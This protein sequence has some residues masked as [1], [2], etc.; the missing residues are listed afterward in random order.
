V[1]FLIL[2]ISG[3]LMLAMICGV[4][5]GWALRHISASTKDEQMQRTL[6]DARARVPQF[7][8]LIRSRDVQINHLKEELKD[9]DVRINELAG[10]LRGL[11]SKLKSSLRKKETATTRDSDHTGTAG[12]DVDRRIVDRLEGQL[13]EACAQ[14]ADAMTEASAAETELRSLKA[15]LELARGGN[16]GSAREEVQDIAARLNK[17]TMDYDSLNRELELEQRR[18]QELERERELQNKSLQVLHQQL[19]MERE[20][21]HRTTAD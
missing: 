7:E 17:K 13:E 12:A 2:K 18:V 5:A 8:T 19:E 10:E 20:R 14:A 11:E 21:A 1:T 15:K 4:S 3:Y 9:K 16:S 6:G